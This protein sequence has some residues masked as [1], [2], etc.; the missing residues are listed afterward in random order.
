[1]AKINSKLATKNTP[2]E[3]SRREL[4]SAAFFVVCCLL[5]MVVLA[6]AS[7]PAH[8]QTAD[9]INGGVT[10]LG[11]AKCPAGGVGNSACYS[12][13]VQCSGIDSSGVGAIPVTVKVTNPGATKGAI[14]FVSPGGG[15]SYYDQ[16]FTYGAVI[17]NSAL[18]A[19]FTAIQPYFGTINGW[20]QGPAPNG[21]RSLSCR[22]A[23][24]ANWAA[25]STSP[26]MH[27][28]GTALCAAGVSAGSSVVV[29]S[30]AHYGMGS[31]ATRL[32]DMVEITSGPTFGRLDHGCICNQP[33]LQTSTGQGP[34]S[35]CY[36]TIGT[37]VDNTY[38][39]AAC[40]AAKKNHSTTNEELLYHDSIMSDDQPFLNYTTNVHIVFGAQN[41][42]G[43][44]IPQGLE[45]A[46]YVTSP[47]TINVVQD[48][49][50]LVPDSFDGALQVTND[51]V[52]SCVLQTPK[53]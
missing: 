7:T 12:L 37:L 11:T 15:T 25:T 50:H 26:L 40:S 41:D 13:S 46:D 17:V 45:W 39:T 44:A 16:S 3:F 33:P 34:L 38:S 48:A 24:L 2:D 47:I 28:S 1:M 42:E 19:G 29:Y 10:Y 8:A 18:Q 53:H 20:L 6:L 43:A 31:G 9:P 49:A 22:F 52:S 5:A 4:L 27:Q 14:I 23:A 21:A 51:L 35:D 32:F 36:L 30:L